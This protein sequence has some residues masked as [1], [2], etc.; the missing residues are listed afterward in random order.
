MASACAR[1]SVGAGD[2]IAHHLPSVRS[3][4]QGAVLSKHRQHAPQQRALLRR[5][6]ELVRQRGG[7]G[8]LAG[9]RPPAELRE[10]A[11]HIVGGE[12]FQL[13]VQSGVARQVKLRGQ[14]CRP[15][16]GCGGRLGRR[17]QEVGRRLL[18]AG[19]QRPPGHLVEPVVGRPEP[20]AAQGLVGGA[21]QTQAVE[22]RQ[23]PPLLVEQPDD[24]PTVSCR[25]AWPGV[26]SSRA[27]ATARPC[28][29]P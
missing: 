27:W 19:R 5:Q 7:R 10:G 18:L 17:R 26:G 12:R 8:A 23:Q 22:L 11:H 2:R 9:P 6:R 3:G 13:A 15:A 24:L 1:P 16:A 21:L 4:A 14:P 20:L 25:P 29:R 28:G